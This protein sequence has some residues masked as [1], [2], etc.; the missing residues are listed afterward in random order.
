MHSSHESARRRAR[1]GLILGLVL[2]TAL[3]TG[4]VTGL[5]GTGRAEPFRVL[6]VMS[7]SPEFP[8]T[9]EIMEGIESVLGDKARITWFHMDTK[10]NLA[11]GMNKA[12]EA[13]AL[14]H[15][16]KPDG[17]IACDDNAQSMFVVPHLK[18]K[19]DTP[20]AFCG[21]NGD[22]ADYGYPAANVTGVKER[23]HLAESVAFAQQLDPDIRSICYMVKRSPTA[24]A[25]HWEVDR[26]KN[27]LP[28][29]SLDFRYPETLE[30]ALADAREMAGYCDLL[31]VA[32]LEG[33]ADKDGRPV[34]DAEAM[35][36][37]A[38]AFNGPTTGTSAYAIKL[39]L[40]CAVV[41][42]GQEQGRLAAEQ[43]LKAMTGTPIKDIPVTANILG[44]RIINV[45]EMRNLGISP[46]PLVLKGAELTRID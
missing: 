39:G 46:K 2:A 34:P 10:R 1:G 32:A 44:K 29:L 11:G 18:D 20:V 14:Y 4:L 15:K 9:L 5:P 30:G 13:L 26:L 42:T 22:P 38:R 19:V 41:K 45:T 7:Y 33:I 3:V 27:T 17:V 23:L 35:P 25:L 24:D 8:W 6:A 28:A 43:L 31:F 12:E 16:I 40:L 21:V 37:V 36:A